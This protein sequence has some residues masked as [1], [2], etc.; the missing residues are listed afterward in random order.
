MEI[1]LADAGQL[2][3]VRGYDRHIPPDRLADCIRAHRV[4]VLKGRETVAG[5]LRYS[6]FWQTIPFLDLLFLAE[7]CRGRG[8]GRRMMDRWETDMAAL[9]HSYVMLSTQADETA[10]YFYEKLGYRRIGAFLP[11]E[12]EAEEILYGKEIHQKE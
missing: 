4:Y 10:K 7:A 12:Q 1:T 6:L 2:D 5:V 8:F 11:P 3:A 9:G